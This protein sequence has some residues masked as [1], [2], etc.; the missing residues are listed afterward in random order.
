MRLRIIYSYFDSSPG[1]HRLW[2]T[3]GC[4]KEHHSYTRFV[5]GCDHLAWETLVSVLWPT[6]GGCPSGPRG[7][8]VAG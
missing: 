7:A 6:V 2:E 3:L 1:T 5:G 8:S 4:T